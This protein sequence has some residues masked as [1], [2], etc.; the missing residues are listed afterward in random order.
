[1]I[2]ENGKVRNP[3]F[4]DYHLLT[5]L[6]MPEMIPILV[7]CPDREGPFGAKGLG[8][9]PVAPTPAAISNAVAS[10]LGVRIY[11]LPL[12]P[13]RVYWAIHNKQKHSA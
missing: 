9:P 3:S 8:E 6:D 5:T 1:V 7:E 13:E 11:D 2:D 10:V 12:T 4:L